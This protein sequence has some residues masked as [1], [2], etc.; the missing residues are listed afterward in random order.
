V[1]AGLLEAFSEPCEVC[2]GRGV[3]VHTEPVAE[4]PRAADAVEKVKEVASATTNRRRGRKS[5]GAQ[6]APEQPAGEQATATA[7]ATALAEV[8]EEPLAAEPAVADFPAVDAGRAGV[9]AASAE[10]AGEEEDS[11]AG[12][13]RRFRRGRRRGAR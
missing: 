5:A 10:S 3:V 7:T 2:K 13:F 1:G 11:V 12:V 4:R 8:S 6:P 9:G